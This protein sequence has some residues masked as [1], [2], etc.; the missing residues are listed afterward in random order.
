VGQVTLEKISFRISLATDRMAMGW[1]TEELGFDS[2]KWQDI[3]LF[4]IG[5]I[6]ALG[7]T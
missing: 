2:R 4:P 3:F 5:F 7:P 1:M 6:Q